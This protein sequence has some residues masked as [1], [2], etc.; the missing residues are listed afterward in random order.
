M[1]KIVEYEIPGCQ[2]FAIQYGSFMLNDERTGKYHAWSNGCGIGMVHAALEDTKAELAARV[3]AV[4]KAE[5]KDLA[6]RL[7]AVEKVLDGAEATAD[8]LDTLTKET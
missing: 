1:K 3:V 5:Q 4:L 2:S 7:A 8:W 6:K